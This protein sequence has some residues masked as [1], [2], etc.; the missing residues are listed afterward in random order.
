MLVLCRWTKHYRSEG[1]RSKTVCASMTEAYVTIVGDRSI[2][3]IGVAQ[4]LSEGCLRG[5]PS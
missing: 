5:R 4:G 1:D 3:T 2:A